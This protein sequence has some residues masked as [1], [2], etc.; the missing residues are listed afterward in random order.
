MKDFCVILVF[1]KKFVD[2]SHETIK[3]IRQV[4]KYDGDIVCIISDDLKDDVD[5]LYHD[6]NIIIKHL[7]N[8]EVFLMVYKINFLIVH[9]NHQY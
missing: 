2:K 8:Q 3:Q 1:N 5:L 4:G 9:T 7:G 6:E